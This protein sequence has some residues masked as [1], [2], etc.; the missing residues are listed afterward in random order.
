MPCTYDDS[1]ER[2][3]AARE[4]KEELALVTSL[5]CEFCRRVYANEGYAHFPPD[6]IEWFETHDE[7]DRRRIEK[8]AKDAARRER[9]QLEG[10]ER[11]VQIAR[12]E[13]QLAEAKLKKLEKAKSTR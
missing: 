12:R 4:V 7:V 1:Y 8:E 9:E 13:L 3:E 2:A 11:S 10:A 6:L 5:L